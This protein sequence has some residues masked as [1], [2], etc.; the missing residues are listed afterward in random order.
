M[1]KFSWNR[2][3]CETLPTGRGE[4]DKGGAVQMMPAT[5]SSMV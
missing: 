5:S 4:E 1:L 3:D 2:Y